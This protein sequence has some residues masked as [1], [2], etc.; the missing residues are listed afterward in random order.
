MSAA[1][2]WEPRRHV[3]SSLEIPNFNEGGLRAAEEIIHAPDHR[4]PAAERAGAQL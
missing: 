2:S 1:V 4:G 3:A